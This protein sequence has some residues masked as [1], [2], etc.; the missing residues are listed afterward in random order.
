MSEDDYESDYNK[1]ENFKRSIQEKIDENKSY[2]DSS[3]LTNDDKKKL[4]DEIDN[5]N[6]SLTEI[7]NLLTQIEN[8]K[9][10]NNQII[11]YNMKLFLIIFAL[12]VLVLVFLIWYLKAKNKKIP[13]EKF[14]NFKIL[15]II[16][17]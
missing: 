11:K 8:L 13:E 14:D 16:K 3:T 9:S 12:L 10:E 5:L 6:K 4:Q 15:Q 2:L 1:L 17:N 7:D